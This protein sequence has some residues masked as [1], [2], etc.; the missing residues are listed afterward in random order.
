MVFDGGQSPDHCHDDPVACLQSLPKPS[1]RSLDIRY[2]ESAQIKAQRDHAH[3]IL[4]ESQ[5]FPELVCLTRTDRHDPRRNPSKQP[6]NGDVDRGLPPA[7]IPPEDVSMK[8]MHAYGHA[9]EP[10][11]ESTKRPSLRGVSVNDLR[12]DPAT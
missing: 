4:V 3:V 2:E 9:C 6:L 12:S 11:G 8:R 7:E 1:T 10:R 5:V